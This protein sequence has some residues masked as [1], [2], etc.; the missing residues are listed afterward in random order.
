LLLSDYITANQ[1]YIIFSGYVTSSTLTNYYSKIES[2]NLYHSKSYI[3]SNYTNTTSLN[4]LLANKLD[5]SVYNTFIN[6]LSLKFFS[7]LSNG[8]LRKNYFEYAD[9]TSTKYIFFSQNG[10]NQYQTINFIDDN[11]LQAS[12]LIN[13]SIGQNQLDTTFYNKSVYCYENWRDIFTGNI[14]L[15][16]LNTPGSN[17]NYYLKASKT[18]LLT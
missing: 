4:S 11:T 6:D 17:G 14:S 12:K 8:N 7:P 10:T 18:T 5:T 15:A 9:L 1:I 2:D 13:N 3:N 16:A